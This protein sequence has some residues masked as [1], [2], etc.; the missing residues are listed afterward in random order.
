MCV[1]VV[2]CFS[3]FSVVHFAFFFPCAFFSFRFHFSLLFSIRRSGSSFFRKPIL[4]TYQTTLNSPFSPK[5]FYV[6]GSAAVPLVHLVPK[7]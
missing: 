7:S 4:D 1:L 2:G 6:S 5:S 3:S